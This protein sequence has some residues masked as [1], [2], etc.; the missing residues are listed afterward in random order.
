M[1]SR[2]NIFVLVENKRDSTNS[3][4]P[5]MA[6]PQSHGR[7]ALGRKRD[8]ITHEHLR[9]FPESYRTRRVAK[10]PNLAAIQTVDLAPNFPPVFDQGQLGSCTANALLGAYEFEM[11]KQKEPLANLSRL[12]LYYQE[13][14]KE[15]TVSTDSGA[16]IQDGVWVL[17]AGTGVC[18]ESLWSYDIS[19]FTV[20]PS[21]AALADAGNHHVVTA[22]RLSGS[23][24]DLRQTLVNGTPVVF[25]IEVFSEMMSDAVASTGIV[26]M[27]TPDEQAEGGHAICLAGYD[28]SSKLFK[29]RNS[30]GTSWGDNGYGYLPY[31]YVTNSQYSSDFWALTVVKDSDTP[32]PQPTPGPPPPPQPTPDPNSD[33][34]FVSFDDL[35]ASPSDYLIA[36]QNVNGL[37]VSRR[38]LDTSHHKLRR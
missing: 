11:L 30:W 13:R 36:V 29:F 33:L 18:S 37:L 6:A 10:H 5:D 32:A 2:L 20:A 17:Q 23:L 8:V 19:Q 9:R 14:A 35:L 3:P 16:E 28:D 7:F 15:G 22:Q 1:S 4:S 38:Q 27:P 25:G 24:D 34:Q 12:F 21:P 26:P 31:D